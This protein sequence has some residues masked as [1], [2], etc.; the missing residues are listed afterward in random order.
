MFTFCVR[1][2]G[3]FVAMA[4]ILTLLSACGTT[5]TATTTASP[6]TT[7][8]AAQTDTR[9]VVIKIGAALPSSGV[10]ARKVLDAENGAQLAIDTANANNLL[11]GYRLAFNALNDTGTTGRPD[12]TTAAANAKALINDGQTAGMLG[13]FDTPSAQAELPLTNSAPL[14]MISPF[15]TNPCLT[16]QDPAAGCSGSG[17]VL[18][19]VR[20]TGNVTF[21][22]IVPTDVQ[23][24][25]VMA[26][27]LVQQQ[28]FKK[29]W[30]IDDTSPSGAAL[31]LGFSSEWQKQG[32]SVI[33]HRSVAPTS[34][35]EGLLTLIAATK[36]D[37]IFYAGGDITGGTQ[38]RQ[39][40]RM[41]PGL[42]NIPFAGG[43]GIHTT[44]FASAIG[45]TGGPDYCTATGADVT[46]V[47]SA[48]S[49]VQQYQAKYGQPPSSYS[50]GG[51]D[52]VNLLI[53]A[54]KTAIA[55]GA[56][57]PATA[58]NTAAAK[59]FRQAVINAVAKSSYDG[60]ASHYSFNADGDPVS[61]SIPILTLVEVISESGIAEPGWKQVNVQ[62]LP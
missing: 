11:P 61:V 45:L 31:A 43:E 39:Q 25:T 18:G 1:V 29:V 21:F 62:M 40:M 55:G 33:D 41:I 47:P 60:V 37:L 46:A 12:A 10:D 44:A 2:G 42:Q 28:H 54:I 35:Y 57:P 24:G 30:V 16:Q 22:R 59:L 48:A 26:D 15:A 7:G 3:A 8:T 49:F 14:V 27:Y 50:A 17:T 4:L 34:S 20:P 36:P 23:Q 6:T 38:I 51:F 58:S 9:P 13:P 56:K 32:G 19:T 52:S 53:A 5:K